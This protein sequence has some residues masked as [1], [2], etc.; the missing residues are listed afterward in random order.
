MS[1]SIDGSGSITG[2]DQGLNVSGVLTFDD[3]TNVDSVGLVTARSGLHVTSGNTGIGL[4]NP[5]VPLHIFGSYPTLKIQNSATAQYASASIDLQGPA[6]DERYTKI[7]HG[8]SNTGGTETYFQI[9]QYNA[10]GS[11]VKTLA[12]YNYQYDYWSFLTGGT[13]R[14]KVDYSGITVTGDVSIADKI[15]HT[16]D[17]DTAIRFPAADTFT[18]ETAG[19][20]RLR[21]TADG[22][23]GIGTDNP[24]K[25]LSI[26]S[27]Q[28]V[29]M[30][31]EGTTSTSR[32]GFKVP[33]TTNN[34][35][36]GAINGDD[37]QIRTGGQERFLIHSDGIITKPYQVAFFAYCNIGSHDLNA[38]DKFQFNT[39][40]P[41]TQKVAVNTNHTTYNGTNVFDTTNNR[42]T[43]PVAGLYHFTV[44]GYFNRTSDPMTQICPRVNNVQVT[45]GSNDVFFFSHNA[46]TAGTTLSGSVT[47]QLAA[48]DY[49][50]VHRRS[51][52]QS[53]T[54][55]FYGPHSHFCGHLI[56]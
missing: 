48:N 5:S 37:F 30:L 3:V 33:T 21:I 55:R 52:S 6:G 50:S 27:S 19:S 51:N 36:V 23:V 11:Y 46:I 24:T 40:P 45:N 13:E 16:G 4:N 10:A 39:L 38:G 31:L 20:E 2:I 18:V 9:E 34:P 54:T 49:V 32:I 26:L 8:N 42:F 41:T 14:L 29:M 43:A 1:I 15:V 12:Q 35:T 22:K 53:G 47:L 28:S 7:L 25:S 17:T 56:G 44:T